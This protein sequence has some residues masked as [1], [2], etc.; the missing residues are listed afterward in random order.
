ML[1]VN[2]S[3]LLRAARSVLLCLLLWQAGLWDGNVYMSFIH[4]AT[5]LNAIKSLCLEVWLHSPT[6]TLA[7]FSPTHTIIWLWSKKDLFKLIVEAGNQ[8]P[9][10][11]WY[12]NMHSASNTFTESWLQMYCHICSLFFFNC[13]FFSIISRDVTENDLQLTLPDSNLWC[14]NNMIS[15]WM[16]QDL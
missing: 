1:V 3:R 11:C 10:L 5:Q 9:V 16:P 13:A 15:V 14:C 8:T 12:Q 7:C 2:S 6:W 4:R